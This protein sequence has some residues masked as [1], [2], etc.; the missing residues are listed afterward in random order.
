MRLRGST[1]IVTGASTGI[2]RETA[3]L[4]ARAGS[5]LVVAARDE[6]RLA[7]ATRELESCSGRAI[8]V[9]TDVTDRQAV[10]AMV[11]RAAEEF[12]RVDVL[13]NNAGVGLWA[14][15]ADGSM[16]NMRRVFE[17]NLFGAIQC[18]QAVVPHM[19]RQRR[20]QI[21]NVSSIAGRIASPYEGAYAASKFA[22][23]AVSDALRLELA[24]R[25]INVVTIYPGLTE[26]PFHE[27]VLKEMQLPPPPGVARPVPPIQVARA[28]VRAARRDAREVY[29]TPFDRLAAGLKGLSPRFID[30]GMRRFWLGKSLTDAD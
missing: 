5:N 13:V 10:E 23:T 21:V 20:G 4:F 27:N 22:L 18:I 30:W 17:V 24:D 2:G 7:Q 25:G 29:V 11:T 3:R 16:A 1:V 14:P 9:P 19:R 15:L 8:A 6:E 26:T 12:G 28:I